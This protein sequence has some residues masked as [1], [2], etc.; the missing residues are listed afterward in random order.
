MSSTREQKIKQMEKE[1]LKR[2]SPRLQVSI[3][4]AFTAL[5]GALTSFAML[6]AGIEQMWLRYAVAVLV[7]YGAFLLLLRLWLWLQKRSLDI[8]LPHLDF[9]SSGGSG[10]GGGA[11][12]WQGGGGNFGGGGASGSWENNAVA[13]SLSSSSSPPSTSSGGSSSFADIISFDAD[14]G[15]LVVIAIVALLAGLI[16]TLYVVYTAPALLAEIL[17]DGALVAGL[18]KRVKKVEQKNW[19]GSAVRLTIIP[20]LLV[21][22]FVTIA[23]FALQAAAPEARSIGEVWKHFM[24]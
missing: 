1:L 5:A 10:G 8:D 15:I 22:V 19:L 24:T 14:E 9:G 23:G 18:Y 7:A 4:L 6:H 17:V 2:S 20:A 11:S 13:A 12:G 3:I 16:A 21:A